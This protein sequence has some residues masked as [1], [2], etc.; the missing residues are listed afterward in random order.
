MGGPIVD[1]VNLDRILHALG[2]EGQQRLRHL[3]Q[4]D[5]SL[6]LIA[7][8]TRLDRTLSDQA[9]P[10]YAFFTTTRLEP[11]DVDESAAMLTAIARER[12]D[13]D[14]VEYLAA[15]E[16]RARLRT[17]MHLAGGQPRMWATL[18]SALTVGGLD[19]LVDLLLT[20]F[21]DLTPYYQE[22]LGRLSGQQRLVVAELAEID[23]PINVRELAERL[24]IEQRSLA[25]TISE[26]VDRG[27]AAETTSPVTALLDRRRTYYELAEPL[28]RLSFQIKESRGEPLRLVVEFVKHW[29]DPTDLGSA[30]SEGLVAEY[31]LLAVE[32]HDQ[33]AVIAVTRRL[34]TPPSHARAGCRAAR[35]DRRCARRARAQQ[36]GAVHSAS[37]RRCG[38]RSRPISAARG[39]GD[40][41]REIRWGGGADRWT[42]TTPSD[43]CLD[44]PLSGDGHE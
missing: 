17:I 1:L 23:R 11:F 25:K 29:F 35:G 18:A 10:F 42:Y 31:V 3:L 28:A 6:L 19:E 22:Q 16:G 2:D 33:D 40:L 5:R 32:G 20:R 26:L 27:S 39:L 21:D 24:E 44:R 14:L 7:T 15:D 36:P 13:D 30:T 38:S 8:S 41:R 43:G 9:S 37:R 4:A 34:P 12:D